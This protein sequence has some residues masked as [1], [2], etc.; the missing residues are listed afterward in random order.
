MKKIFNLILVCMSCSICG[1]AQNVEPLNKLFSNYTTSWIGND[2]GWQATHIPHDMLNLFVSPN[3]TVAS[4]CE[5]DE[6]GS[7]VAVFKDGELIS[8]PE[9]SGTGGWGRFSMASV[10]LDSNY[11]YQ[12]LSQNGCDGANNELN[13]NGLPQFP[14]CNQNQEWKVVRRYHISTGLAAPFAEGYGYQGDMLLVGRGSKR[15]LTGLAITDDE[16]FVCITDTAQLNDSIKVYNKARLKLVRQF[17]IAKG[18]GQMAADNQGGLW[19]VC[20]QQMKRFSQQ[21]GKILQSFMLPKD[22]VAASVSFDPYQNRLLIP[23]CGKDLN[24]LIYTNIFSAPTL[25]ATFGEKGGIFS[26]DNYH[27]QGQVGPLRFCGPRGVGVDRQGNIYIANQF[28]SGGRGTI[29]E[30]YNEKTGKRNWKREGLIFTATADFDRQNS[31]F[32]YSPEKIHRIYLHRKGS[33]ADELM[34]CTADPFSFPQDQRCIKGGPFITSTFKRTIQGK[35]FLFVS[36]MYGGMLAGYRFDRKRHGYVGIPFL[37]VGNGDP[38]N[39]RAITFWNDRNGDGHTQLDELK[40]IKEPNQFSMSFFVDQAGNIWR[41]T[42]Q[43]GFL[44]WRMTRLKNGIPQYATGKLFS[45]PEGIDGVKRIWYDAAKDELFLAGFSD[46]APDT[47]DTWWCMG[48]TITTYNHALQKMSSGKWQ[49]SQQPQ[50]KL[51]IPFHVEDDSKLDY[52]DAKAFCVEGD[53][54]FV[55][56]ARYG[57]IAVYAR[58]NGKFLG[59]LQPGPEVKEQSGWADFNYCIHAKKD[60]DG[61]YYIFNEENAFGK[62]LL[63]AIKDFRQTKQ[64]DIIEK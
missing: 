9:G 61:T 59:R 12:L 60:K 36:D 10:V 1:I 55:A 31:D 35:D 14:P 33:R 5:W 64:A 6:G 26:K 17:E 25:T 19:M 57:C 16:L 45:L 37:N 54:I 44:F 23:N 30:S 63:Y 58:N 52:T 13:Q 15:L 42:R 53:Y 56:L 50:M 18:G 48:S 49:Q 11:V 40:P 29:L 7:N 27:L 43:Q 28:V 22:V 24:I 41:G 2:G 51:H 21:D 34:A 47:K 62:I 32:V 4:V 46:E 3:G 38:D 39:K 8:V 20:G